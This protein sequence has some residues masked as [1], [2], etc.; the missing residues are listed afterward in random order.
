MITKPH[1]LKNS[2]HCCAWLA[3]M[4]SLCHAGTEP[5][6]VTDM[7]ASTIEATVPALDVFPLVENPIP[8]DN[9]I[10]AILLSKRH[11]L[12]LRAD[13]S[14]VSEVVNQIYQNS[15]FQPIWLTDNRSEKNLQDM[16]RILNSA[17]SNALNPTNYDAD[18]IQEWIDGQNLDDKVTASYDVALTVSVVSYLR[19]LRQGQVDLRDMQYPVHIAP[20]PALD[21]AGLLQQ[22]LSSE[23]LTELVSLFEP[24]AKQYQQLKQVLH[25]LQQL[26]SQANLD[27]FKLHK[28]LRP[29]DR[30]SQIPNLRQRLR[31][32]GVL[33]KEIDIEDKTYADDVVAAVKALQQQ[34]GLKADGVIGPAT[35]GLLNQSP[36]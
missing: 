20:K 24:K 31:A 13:F 19:D 11:P 12:L 30:H 36:R 10:G 16:V 35:G 2:R 1:T 28:L 7:P 22:H 3:L 18:R 8:A 15:H 9:P 23:T 25:G 27:E 26:S 34:Q 32:M 21:I 4:S 17:P 5:A 14:R 6:M 29:G 33:D